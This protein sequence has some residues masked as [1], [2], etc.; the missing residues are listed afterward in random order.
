MRIRV[1]VMA[2]IIGGFPAGAQEV[3]KASGNQVII[4]TVDSSPDEAMRLAEPEYKGPKYTGR[5][6]VRFGS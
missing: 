1:V 5:L 2:L 6:N 4:E 3:H